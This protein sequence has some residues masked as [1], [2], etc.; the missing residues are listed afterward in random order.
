MPATDEAATSTLA[1]CFAPPDGLHGQLALLCG[2]SADGDFIESALERFTGLDPRHRARSGHCAMVLATD[3]TQ[4]RLDRVAACYHL[5][6]RPAPTFRVMHAKVGILLFGPGQRS[7]TSVVRLIVSTGNWT[8]FT[9]RQSID[10]IW[11]GDLLEAQ[12]GGTADP[13]LGADVLAATGFFEALLGHYAAPAV[14]GRR[15]GDAFAAVR[16]LAGGHGPQEVPPRFI[17][18]ICPSATAGSFGAFPAGSMGA[19]VLGRFAER[20]KKGNLLIHGSGFF[21]QSDPR[22]GGVEP[23][24]LQA[25]AAALPPAS[26]TAWLERWLACNP[27]TAGAAADWIRSGNGEADGWIWCR[28]RHPHRPGEASF[29]AKYLMLAKARHAGGDR[30]ISDGQLYLGSANLSLQGFALAPG[31]GGNVEAGMVL[32]VEAM[33]EGD[34]CGRLGID[35]DEELDPSEV[36]ESPQSEEDEVGQSSEEPPPFV[37][38]TRLADPDRLVLE[39]LPGDRRGAVVR[40]G[41]HRQEVGSGEEHP[42]IGL[43]GLPPP[44]PRLRVEVGDASWLIPVFGADGTFQRPVGPPCDFDDAVAHLLDF[45]SICW[46]DGAE[47][48]SDGA[49]DLL[50]GVDAQPDRLVDQEQTRRS[51]PIHQAMRLVET[52]AERNQSVPAELILDW[53][54]HLRRV[55]LEDMDRQVARTIAG[56]EVDVLAPLRG[57]PGFAPPFVEPAYVE[58]IDE[59]RR[60]WGLDRS[61]TLAPATGKAP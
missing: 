49:E 14:L 13:Q 33:D 60:A 23:K 42:E 24:V 43:D 27:G 28:T 29:H 2:L 1:D 45:P 4:F 21:E 30:R 61:P 31:G 11:S 25:I 59:V 58:L 19:Q 47:D 6:P 26:R 48:G 22:A 5:V 50:V 52:V 8:T 36:P 54:E 56:L 18:T 38:A 16:A 17:S 39:R 46:D 7:A 15:I 51:F 57:E 53:V 40:W 3:R 32:E 44:P 20:S 37:A 12:R 55:L 35:P 41:E 34:L 9:A 10:L